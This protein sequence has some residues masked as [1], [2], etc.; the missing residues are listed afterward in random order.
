MASISHATL[1]FA[2]FKPYKGVSSNLLT[3]AK[4]QELEAFQTL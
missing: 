2:G 3:E 4:M 1:I